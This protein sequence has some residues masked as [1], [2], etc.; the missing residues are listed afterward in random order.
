MFFSLD[1]LEEKK[2]KNKHKMLGENMMPSIDVI[3][4]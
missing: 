1:V 3:N 2:E 4:P